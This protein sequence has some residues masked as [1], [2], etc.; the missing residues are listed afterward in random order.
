MRSISDPDDAL[1]AESR[2]KSDASERKIG[3]AEAS[4][5]SARPVRPHAGWHSTPDATCSGETG[6]AIMGNR[7]RGKP[8]IFLTGPRYR[9]ESQ[10]QPWIMDLARPAIP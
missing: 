6:G 4:T 3:R 7:R 9:L 2:R 5:A 10:S 8:A 1:Q